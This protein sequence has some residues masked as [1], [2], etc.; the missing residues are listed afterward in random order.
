MRGTSRDE[1]RGFVT[2]T[3]KPDR[4]SDAPSPEGQDAA[5]FAH[6]RARFG[7]LL[8]ALR[9][10]GRR[11]AGRIGAAVKR[12]RG[13]GEAVAAAPVEVHS[14]NVPRWSRE[15]SRRSSTSDARWLLIWSIVAR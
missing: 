13:G 1:E 9:Q 5:G 6:S 4:P 12:R 10:D 14:G 8:D 2:S 15:T 11:A 3:P 7:D